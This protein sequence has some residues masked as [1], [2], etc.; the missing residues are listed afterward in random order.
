VVGWHD[1]IGRVEFDGEDIVANVCVVCGGVVEAADGWLVEVP[2]ASA[3]RVVVS[4]PML[5]I[6]T[7]FVTTTVSVTWSVTGARVC[8][9]VTVTAPI[10]DVPESEPEPE[11]ELDPP[12]PDPPSIGTTE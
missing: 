6:W 4:G 1:T 2:A 10:G 9:T 5:T 3:V 12:G 11:P 8:T 7:V